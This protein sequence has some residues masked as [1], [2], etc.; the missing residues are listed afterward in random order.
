MDFSTSYFGKPLTKLVYDDIVDYFKDERKENEAIEFKSFAVQ[1]T[2][3]TGLQGVIRGLAAFLN[4]SGGILIWGAPKG[5][6]VAAKAEDVFVGDLCPVKE[7]VEKDRLINKIS[8]AITPLPVGIGVQILESGNNYIYVFEIQQGIYRPHQYD[9]RYYVRLDGQTKPAPHYLVD[10]LVKQISYPNICGVIKF[11]KMTFDRNSS[12]YRLPFTLGMFNF[13]ELQNEE[14]VSFRILCVGGY[15]TKG[16]QQQYT[17][18]KTKY[19][20]NGHQLIY[21]DFAPVLSYGTPH[22]FN[23]VLL[24]NDETLKETKG[25][26]EIAL[27]FGGRK[28]PA[29]STTYKLNFNNNVK[30][31]YPEQLLV[32]SEENVLFSELKQKTMNPSETLDYFKKM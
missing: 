32:E 29:K 7:L 31:D 22:I 30:L 26:L 21:E 17:T 2:F 15:F 23:D 14:A 20:M 11:E 27:S 6:K 5:T 16:R 4:S 10:A 18:Q 24:I 8:S 1:A 19:N 25:F 9:G 28:S 3:D 13:S 12:T